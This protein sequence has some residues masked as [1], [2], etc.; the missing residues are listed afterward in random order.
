M[1]I[2]LAIRAEE[3]PSQTEVLAVVNTPMRWRPFFVADLPSLV[4]L[5]AEL[6]PVL[7]GAR[8]A[9]DFE[10]RARRGREGSR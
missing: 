10:E 7:A 1:A 2:H 4:A 8:D 9:P 3:G 6:G 5:I